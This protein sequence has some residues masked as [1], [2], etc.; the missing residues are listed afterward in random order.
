MSIKKA[1]PR[2]KPF[3]KGFKHNNSAKRVKLNPKNRELLKLSKEII[4][5][6][7]IK[8]FTSQ[9]GAIEMAVND[10][11]TLMGEIMVFGIAVDA[12]KTGNYLKFEWLA[13]QAG[14]LKRDVPAYIE[15]VNITRRKEF[16]TKKMVENM[17]DKELDTLYNATKKF[18]ELESETKDEGEIQQENDGEEFSTS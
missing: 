16:Y 8:C 11:N 17:D 2:G 15:E 13:K 12:A 5:K 4:K 18:I 9:R 3:K 1:L 6:A 10:P 14:L 7:V